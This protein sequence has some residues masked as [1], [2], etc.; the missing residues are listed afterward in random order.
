MKVFELEGRIV[1]GFTYGA[2][3]NTAKWLLN[4]CC[5]SVVREKNWDC[6]REKDYEWIDGALKD[7]Y[8]YYLFEKDAPQDGR[9]IASKFNFKAY[10]AFVID[11]KSGTRE[12]VLVFVPIS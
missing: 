1:W 9:L 8:F 2:F 10:E 3:N 4:K 7:D 6:R 12:L 11:P 5:G